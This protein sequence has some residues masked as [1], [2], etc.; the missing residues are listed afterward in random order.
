MLVETKGALLR[1]QL[2]LP[3][4]SFPLLQLPQSRARV[5]LRLFLVLLTPSSSNTRQRTRRHLLRK[6]YLRSMPPNWVT[7]T[8]KFGWLRLRR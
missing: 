2:P 5:V 8:G 4:R 6:S 1:P 7:R 3:P